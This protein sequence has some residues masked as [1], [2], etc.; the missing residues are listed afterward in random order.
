VE[1]DGATVDAVIR[2]ANARFGGAFAAIAA[3]CQVWVNGEPA[4]A[5]QQL[6]GDD[7][8]ALLPPVSG[9]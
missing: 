6:A 7:E 2:S 3:R 8:V 5:T 9:G 4:T 1:I